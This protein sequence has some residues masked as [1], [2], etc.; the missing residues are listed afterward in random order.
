MH[1][2]TASSWSLLPD[3]A[4]PRPC[5]GRGPCS[6]PCSCVGTQPHW[7]LLTWPDLDRG[8]TGDQRLPVTQAGLFSCPV[9]TGKWERT[10]SAVEAACTPRPRDGGRLY[11]KACSPAAIHEWFAVLGWTLPGGARHRAPSAPT[12]PEGPR[13]RRTSPLRPPGRPGS[14]SVVESS[15]PT[16]LAGNKTSA[17]STQ[18]TTQAF[19][20]SPDL[21]VPHQPLIL[22]WDCVVFLIKRFKNLEPGVDQYPLISVHHGQGTIQRRGDM[23]TDNLQG[24]WEIT[25]P[26]HQM[27][28]GV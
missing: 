21:C 4:S 27:C 1:V 24:V 15:A 11:P 16:G 23:R 5:S 18:G 28:Q 6:G 8:S 7:A 13:M 9:G 22:T 20:F 26:S 10:S 3:S 12:C 19:L 14:T 17:L 25:I 2:C